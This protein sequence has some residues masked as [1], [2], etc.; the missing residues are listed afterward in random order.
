MPY[1]ARE[2]E[3][4]KQFRIMNPDG[5]LRQCNITQPPNDPPGLGPIMSPDAFERLLA[6]DTTPD[7]RWSEW[8]FTEA[9]GGADA[10]A[11][12]V[13]ALRQ[14]RDRFIDE[15]TN[16]YTRPQDRVFC[17]AVPREVAEE[18]WAMNEARFRDFM[19]V[20]D[21]DQVKRLRV[22]GYFRDWPG[23]GEVYK[24]VALALTQFLKMSPKVRM[25]NK[26]LERTSQPTLPETPEDFV[27][28]TYVSMAEINAKV[29]HYF[30]Q[31]KARTDIQVKDIYDDDEI[32]A[33]APL[34]Y[35]AA[36]HYGYDLWPWAN[37]ANFEQVLSTEPGGGN[38]WGG[39]RDEWKSRTEN[40]KNVIV[41]IRFKSPVP[42]WMSGGGANMKLNSLS[43]LAL[44][45]TK[46]ELKGNPD[47]WVVFDQE[48]RNTLTIAQV[49]TMIMKEPTRVDPTDEDSP[50]TRGANVYKDVSEAQRVVDS[51]N[52]A[53]VAIKKSLS[54]LSKI[55]VK[56]NV[57]KLE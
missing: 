30:A 44:D 51:L 19:S 4:L 50:K 26:E 10:K 14:I 13:D 25:M 9:G 1:S 2:I 48:N 49:K 24:K 33:V 3:V 45:L 5:T 47:E 8:V 53:L 32:M 31:K 12:S 15:R 21:Q 54:D 27:G 37:R 11:Q 16:G 6:A 20:C 23:N 52:R 55:K 22:F 38:R 46:D 56:S 39:A 57:F 36:V 43:D 7:K 17:P 41:Y 18:R 35:A 34:T 28:K 40:K 42:A 29:E